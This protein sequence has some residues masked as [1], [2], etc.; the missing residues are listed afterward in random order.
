MARAVAVAERSL[1]A[2][3]HDRTASQL[4]A[5]LPQQ[6]LAPGNSCLIFYAPALAAVNDTEN[7]TSL[8]GL[9]DRDFD[10]IRRQTS[11][12]LLMTFSTLTGK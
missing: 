11:G 8:I 4:V 9:G 3:T 2:L 10:G 7:A 1:L 5:D 6:V 12:T